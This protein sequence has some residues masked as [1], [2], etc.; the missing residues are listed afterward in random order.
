MTSISL[1][2]PFSFFLA[3]FRTVRG[4]NWWYAKIPPLLAIAYA[5]FLLKPPPP[6][7]AFATLLGVLFSLCCLASYGHIVNDAFD[8]EEDRRAGKPN[9]MVGKT[10]HQ[11]ASLCLLLVAMGF[12]PWLV[13]DFGSA[14]AV[15]LAANYLLP[16]AYSIPPLR[17]KERGIFGVVADAAGVHAM[18]TLFVALAILHVASITGE[19]FL[20]LLLAA[21]AWSF[22][23]GLRG[24]MIH[25]LW[26]RQNDIQAGT[27]TLASGQ[28]PHR[29]R[30]LI[31]GIVFPAEMLTFGWLIWLVFPFAQATLWVVL[32]YIVFDAFRLR[33]WRMPFDP[34]P[35]AS[36][37][38]TPPADLYEV[39]FP[40][41]LA[42]TLIVRNPLFL[43]LFALFPML[44]Y[45]GLKMAAREVA[46]VVVV[47]WRKHFQKHVR[48]K[49]E[50]ETSDQPSH[51][52]ESATASRLRPA[53]SAMGVNPD[54]GRSGPLNSGG[55]FTGATHGNQKITSPEQISEYYDEWTSRYMDVFG[56]TFQ[57]CR[58]SRVEDLHEYFLSQAGLRDGQRV[59]D[60]GCGVCGPSIYFANKRKIQ[61]EAVTI[62]SFQ[63][64]KALEHIEQ[65]E[66]RDRIHVQQGDY[67]H[68]PDLFP[69][70]YFDTILFL[71]SFSHAINPEH[72]LQG[73]YKVLKPGGVLYIKDLFRKRG[74]NEEEQDRIDR[75]IMKVNQA[76]RTITPDC[77]CA[78]G[79]M[80]DLGFEEVFVTPVKFIQ[81]LEV[82]NKFDETHDFDLFEGATPF[83]W[84]DWLELK[85]RKP[86][87]P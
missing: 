23:A 82:W 79:I 83:Q 31:R 33:T 80:K 34:A 48:V 56:D 59:L 20:P 58:T 71:E 36:G 12:I 53:E 85:F 25:Q 18:P 11:R 65:F 27:T 41:T 63:K 30:R 17:L 9:T 77:D 2:G 19:G 39:W 46:S 57:A 49:G 70:N 67:H 55:V 64:E 60:A 72:V 3:A 21:V 66:L 1:T 7:I 87:S 24:I 44:F 75:V 5:V 35:A 81:D 51:G 52:N 73:A 37:S 28:A 10:V 4:S 74:A 78:V 32:A 43:P 76:F 22:L 38:Y 61:I 68:L 50:T 6:G 29:F 26:D 15:V 16:M 8:I 14:A 42:A 13:L 54:N 40:M 84:V 62:S 45:R 47:Q 86:C 69:S